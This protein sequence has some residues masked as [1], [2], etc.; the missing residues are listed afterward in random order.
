VLMEAVESQK[1]TMASLGAM[2][3]M[4][5]GKGPGLEVGGPSQEPPDLRKAPAADASGLCTWEALSLASTGFWEPTPRRAAFN[6][7]CPYL[8]DRYKCDWDRGWEHTQ[9]WVPQPVGNGEC[10]LAESLR[11]RGVSESLGR[12]PNILVLG[13]SLLR[14]LYE[15]ILCEHEHEVLLYQNLAH[16]DDFSNAVLEHMEL[17]YVFRDY[18]AAI[19]TPFLESHV[20]GEGRVGSRELAGAST[21]QELDLVITNYRLPHVDSILERLFG[22]SSRPPVIYSTH[23]CA[24][25][26]FVE[27]VIDLPKEMEYLEEA[28]AAGKPVFDLCTMSEVAR[29]HGYDVQARKQGREGDPHLCIPG[30]HLDM[31]ELVFQMIVD[32]L[33]T[34]GATS[35]THN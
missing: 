35:S 32:L 17:V 12:K 34:S 15:T 30:P 13:N 24:R 21:R 33:G 19:L 27:E 11:A 6:M 2:R 29:S 28:R 1:E 10:G 31:M 9:R 3:D 8:K 5:A 4:Q 25:G 22:P 16:K 23:G 18:D 26:S 7:S 20:F 14:E